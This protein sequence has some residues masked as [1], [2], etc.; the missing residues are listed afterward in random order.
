M[1]RITQSH[2]PELEGEE[3]YEVETI[4]NHQKWG[5]GYQYFIKWQGYPL[6]LVNT[7]TLIT[8]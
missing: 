5:Q 6:W 7:I 3:V 2:P 4:L 8:K 1:E